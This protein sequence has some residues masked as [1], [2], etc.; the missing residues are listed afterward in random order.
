MIDICDFRRDMKV[1]NVPPPPQENGPYQLL[2]FLK[3]AVSERMVV[4]LAF[5]P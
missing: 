4:M 5:Y 1:H 3:E 2:F